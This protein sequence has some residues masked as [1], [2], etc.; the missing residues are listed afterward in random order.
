MLDGNSERPILFHC[1]QSHHSRPQ[2]RQHRTVKQSVASRTII[3]RS[4]EDEALRLKTRDV[5]NRFRVAKYFAL[6]RDN[7]MA[8]EMVGVVTRHVCNDEW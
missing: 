8:S 4:R 7:T 6:Q 2:S 5:E 1:P 3:F